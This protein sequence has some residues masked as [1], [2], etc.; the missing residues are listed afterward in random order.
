[1]ANNDVGGDLLVGM[2]NI[3]Q[4][5][6]NVSEAT[7]LKWYRELDLPMRKSSK[8]GE[9]GMWMA[10]RKQLDEWSAALGR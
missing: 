10:S 5:L 4:H 8:N 7:V 9:A 6:S 2:K 1:M 3:R